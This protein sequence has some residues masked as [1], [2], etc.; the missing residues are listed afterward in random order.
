MT[1]HI[2]NCNC[3]SFVDT[4][5]SHSPA[6]ILASYASDFADDTRSDDLIGSIWKHAAQDISK[7]TN[8]RARPT[9]LTPCFLLAVLV[10]LPFFFIAST[11]A[12]AHTSTSTHTH[13][14]THSH[15][16]THGSMH[17]C[18]HRTCAG[19]TFTSNIS[20]LL[21]R[22]VVGAPPIAPTA[23]AKRRDRGL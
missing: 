21:L 8:V 18:T 1:S 6:S 7:N 14:R 10:V 11:T 2:H 19:L 5:Y 13:T 22:T 4:E 16:H 15:T 3:A 23:D 17:A 9:P 12:P 20:E